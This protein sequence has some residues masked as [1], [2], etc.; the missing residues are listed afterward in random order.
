MNRV[1]DLILD[2]KGCM[3]DFVYLVVRVGL[4]LRFLFSCFPA[5][6]RDGG[7][8]SCLAYDDGTE[9]QRAKQTR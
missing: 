5:L 4:A 3:S 7:R 1:V 6:S 2:S 9:L 8:L